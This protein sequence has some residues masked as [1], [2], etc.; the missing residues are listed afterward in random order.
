MNTPRVELVYFA[1]CPNV[2]AARTA[3]REAMSAEGLVPQWRE[4]NR[5][6]PA[7]PATLRACGSPTIMINDRDISPANAEAASCRVYA[8]ATSLRGTPAIETIRLAIQAARASGEN[9][10]GH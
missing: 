2:G 3:I 1:G 8:D 9:D 6:D 7:T 10:D 5:D 4:W